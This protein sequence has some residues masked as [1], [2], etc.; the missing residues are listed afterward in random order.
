M[1]A[2]V[3]LAFGDGTIKPLNP[4]WDRRWMDLLARGDLDTLV[5]DSE[6]SIEREADLSAHES[7]T[8]LVARAALPDGRALAC[9]LRYYRAIPEYDASVWFGAVLKAGTP[10]PVVAKLHAA[11]VEALKSPDVVKRFNEQGLDIA[12]RTPAEFGEFMK[13]EITRWSALV[14]ASGVTID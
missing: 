1:A 4:A 7:K 3:A 6:D 13:T 2:G 10:A 5:R 14:K 8:W 11:L 9:T 12:P